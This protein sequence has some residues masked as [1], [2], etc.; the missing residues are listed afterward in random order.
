MGS[1]SKYPRKKEG[2]TY[3]LWSSSTIEHEA[4]LLETAISDALKQSTFLSTISSKKAQWWNDN[5]C[6]MKHNVKSLNKKM[7]RNNNE[8]NKELFNSAKSEYHKAVRKAKRQSWQKFVGSINDPKNMTLLNKVIKRQTNIPLGLLRKNNG[9]FVNSAKD[10]IN[11]LMKNHFP[12]SESLPL[13]KDLASLKQTNNTQF[14]GGNERSGYVQPSSTFSSQNSN[15]H[16][17]TMGD[18]SQNSFINEYKVKKSINTFGPKKAGGLDDF[19]PLVLQNL[20]KN[21]L[22]RLTSL[23]K[24]IIYFGYTPKKWCISKTIFIP[25]P[26][27]TDYSNVRSFRPIS[28]SSFL[29]KALERLVLW[30]IESTTLKENPLSKFQH[31]F[32]KGYSCES[33]LSYLIDNI[34]SAILRNKYALTCQLDVIG[35]FDCLEPKEVISAMREKGIDCKIVAWYQQYLENRYAVNILNGR[36]L[37]FKLRLGCPQGGIISPLAW[38]LVFE[39]F[40]L[41]MNKGP[42][43]ISVFADDGILITTGIDPNTLV[44]NMQ[45]AI[46]SALE[47]GHSKRLTFAAEK[48]VAMLFHRKRKVTEPNKLKVEGTEVPFSSTSKFL[49]VYLD[50]TLSWRFHLEQKIGKA[51]KFLFLLRNA[52]GSIWGPSP[53]ALKWAYNALVVNTLSYCSIVWSKVCTTSIARY[54]LSKL[55]RLAALTMLPARKSTPTSGLEIILGLK[56]LDL[57]IQENALKAI[58]RV[59]P[60]AT[61]NWDGIGTNT[62]SSHL[63]QGIK[64]LQ[65]IG[66]SKFAFDKTNALN[67]DKAYCVITDSFKKGTPD[68]LSEIKAFTDGSKLSNKVGYGYGITT[69]NILLSS[70]NGSLDP[71]NTVFQAEV[72]AI[73][74]A[75]EDLLQWN[76]NEVTI[77]SDSQAAL[78]A[79][80]S[81]IVKSK[82]V[83]SCVKTLNQLA[84]QCKV[85]LKWV[86]AHA[87]YSGN[88]FADFQAKA[89]TSNL[90]NKIEVL[91]PLQWAKLKIS[92]NI[93][94]IWVNRWKSLNEARQT[95]I[96]FPGLNKSATNYLLN[97]SRV[98]LGLC[99]GFLTGHNRMRKHESVVSQGVDPSC[100]FCLEDEESAWHLIAECPALWMHR[101]QA[102][103]SYQLYSNPKWKAHQFLSFLRDAKMS[104]F[105]KETDNVP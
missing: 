50:S 43:K 46:N 81:H 36:I 72:T 38:N 53:R 52:I 89:G 12:G 31:A 17:C 25:K 93:D 16:F 59:Y 54:K 13:C 41:K 24:A 101:G 37:P 65:D 102:F 77:F 14:K 48:T 95:K 45:T 8:L 47:W 70:E 33:A 75:G 88:E 11:L 98:D 34:E 90:D 94:K 35:A 55:N 85:D 68:S 96:W 99:V 71:Q 3:F 40:I 66:I 67:L 19:S 103:K 28:L 18:I 4:E 78:K 2:R 80:D 104:E 51:K 97:Q 79:L 21:F 26:S 61:L 74:K 30:E 84:S 7:L 56:P 32:R 57:Q 9:C 76:F 83:E 15:N 5:L 10:S 60:N 1:F 92:Q 105:E 49:G 82:A 22:T 87:N 44:S 27:K 73:Q 91:A 86:K 58:L 39:S 42:I 69:G 62:S 20:P 29:L 6:K 23:Y 63:R 64:D 100:R